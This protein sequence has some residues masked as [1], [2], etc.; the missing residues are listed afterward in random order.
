M[1]AKL[2][3]RGRVWKYGDDLDS[4]RMAPTHIWAHTTVK[5]EDLAKYAWIGIDPD[6]H[7]KV[8]PGD[9]IVAGKNCGYGSSRGG[10][11]AKTLKATHLGGVVAESCSRLFARSCINVGIP[12]WSCAGITQFADEGDELEVNLE[13]G[14]VRNLTKGTSKQ[15][16][17]PSEISLKILM[18]G[19]L[20]EYIKSELKN[21]QQ[22][23]Q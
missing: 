9:I 22:S 21:K 6:F 20:M 14:E 4:E 23:A 18:A 17:P 11:H 5:D 7:K 3:L 12:A 1:D 2:I 8:R 15:A 19:G 10:N 16:K 13:T